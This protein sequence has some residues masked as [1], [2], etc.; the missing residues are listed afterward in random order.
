MRSVL[1]LFFLL[2]L[3]T[4]S[5]GQ[6]TIDTTELYNG[7]LTHKRIEF[8]ASSKIQNVKYYYKN[9]KI[10]IEYFYTNGRSSSWIAYDLTGNKISEWNDPEIGY[11]KNRKLRDIIFSIT[12][13]CIGGMVVAGCRLNYVK[14]FYWVLCLSVLYPISVFLTEQLI[15]DNEQN[16]VFPLIVAST[17]LILPSLLF[18]LSIL[19]FFRRNI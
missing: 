18:I 10:Q 2:V 5:F 3:F 7:I 12:L 17:L 15:F 1:L 9:G 11:S 14:T 19:N 4:I 6:K 13:L 8:D 16:K